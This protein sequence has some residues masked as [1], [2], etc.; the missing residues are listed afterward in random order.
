MTSTKLPVLSRSAPTKLS[1]LHSKKTE[2]EML[3]KSNDILQ[4]A[5]AWVQPASQPIDKDAS[6]IQP[7]LTDFDVYEEDG[8]TRVP[9]PNV[10]YTLNELDGSHVDP[11]FNPSWWGVKRTKHDLQQE[12][13]R[14][15]K[16]AQDR[17]HRGERP[18]NY[19]RR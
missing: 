1:V 17:G 9:E 16:T 12:Y 2:L 7:H 13:G 3:I 19:S 8:V 11:R 14:V 15:K 10:A 4:S 6:F 5:K 18:P